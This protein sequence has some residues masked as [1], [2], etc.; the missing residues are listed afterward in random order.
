MLPLVLGN[1]PALP[2]EPGVGNPA[3]AF[4]LLCPGKPSL[5]PCPGRPPL[6]PLV[7]SPGKRPLLPELDPPVE[8][9]PPDGL[10]APPDD[11]PEDGIPP[12]EGEEESCLQLTALSASETA[13]AMLDQNL[14]RVGAR[15]LMASS[16]WC[17]L[18]AQ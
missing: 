5:L 18:N 3:D 12:E 2:A 8:G 9:S 10:D 4:P 1:P 15:V 13:S 6:L 14:P 7:A 17:E 11:P 16:R